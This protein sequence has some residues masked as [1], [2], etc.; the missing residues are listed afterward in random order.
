MLKMINNFSKKMR[1]RI[2][3]CYQMNHVKNALEMK[4]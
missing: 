3:S 2:R 4:D 1:N